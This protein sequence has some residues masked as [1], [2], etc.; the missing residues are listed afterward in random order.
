M[1]MTVEV[2]Y[3]DTFSSDK[4]TW[5]KY[6]HHLRGLGVDESALKK[7]V[8]LGCSQVLRQAML[9]ASVG[10]RGLV[11]GAPA[12]GRV[13]KVMGVVLAR[14]A[15]QAAQDVVT[16]VDAAVNIPVTFWPLKKF[17]DA[18]VAQPSLTEWANRMANRYLRVD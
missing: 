14:G 4:V 6:A 9:T 7:L 12:S 5:T 8:D 15:D 18:A 11:P 1:L 3:T 17:L 13:D 2:K 10:E 16:A